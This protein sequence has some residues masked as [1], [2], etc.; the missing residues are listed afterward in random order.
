MPI[1]ET[2]GFASWL[3]RLSILE[4]SSWAIGIAF[5]VRVGSKMYG[6]GFSLDR[7][8]GALTERDRP[9]P[10]NHVHVTYSHIRIIV[11]STSVS[12]AQ[13]W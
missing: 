7:Q 12:I 6:S 13:S 8:D 3:S 1:R 4:H 2:C 9:L 10:N 11:L 5:F